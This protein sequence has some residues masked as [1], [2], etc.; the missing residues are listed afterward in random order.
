MSKEERDRSHQEE[1]SGEAEVGEGG[2]VVYMDVR[3]KVPRDFYITYEAARGIK[4]C[5]GDRI[6]THVLRFLEI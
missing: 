3:E 2:K 1:V 5:L 4:A 6:P